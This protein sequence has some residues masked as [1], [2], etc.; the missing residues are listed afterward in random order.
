LLIPSVQQNDGGPV[1]DVADSAAWRR[2]QNRS[3][4]ECQLGAIP[5]AKPDRLSSPID[6]FTARNARLLSS[7]RCG[8]SVSLDVQPCASN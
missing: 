6:W 7:Q 2:H 4:E 8:L 1:V 5:R 3:R